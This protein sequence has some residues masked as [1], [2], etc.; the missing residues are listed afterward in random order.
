MKFDI[1][2]KV[3]YMA[4]QHGI[5]SIGVSGGSMPSIVAEALSNIPDFQWDRVKIFVVDERNVEVDSAESNIG[6]YLRLI[7][8]A[9]NKSLLNFTIY[10]NHVKTAHMYEATLRKMLLPEQNGQYAR[11][12][13]LLLGVGPDGHTCSLFPG[14]DVPKLTD[15]HWVTA[16]SESPK[17]PSKRVT[18]TMPVLNNAKNLAFIIT[19]KPKSHVVK[20]IYDGDKKYPASQVRPI[21]NRLTLI[22]D[23]DAASDLPRPLPTPKDAEKSPQ[24]M[25]IDE[26]REMDMS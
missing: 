16:V 25:E 10:E 5:I 14:L 22:L 11:F 13:I 1:Q 8:K 26:S 19:G 3:N 17:P 15:H 21:N 12:D 18:L 24:K 6:T 9:H 4:M 20:S 23:E 2:E 7:P